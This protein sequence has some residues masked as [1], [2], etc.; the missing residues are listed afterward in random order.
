MIDKPKWV[1]LK[2]SH[3]S[4]GKVEWRCRGWF[5][6]LLTKDSEAFSHPSKFSTFATKILGA[7]LCTFKKWMKK[8]S[9]DNAIQ[10]TILYTTLHNKYLIIR[11]PKKNTLKFLIKINSVNLTDRPSK[12]DTCHRWKCLGGKMRNSYSECGKIFVKKYCYT[13]DSLGSADLSR[14]I[15]KDEERPRKIR[16]WR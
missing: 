13:K 12:R 6:R 4:R 2:K 16:H 3:Y 10:H 7:L 1:R 9:K 14:R 15:K 8:L 5:P 11:K